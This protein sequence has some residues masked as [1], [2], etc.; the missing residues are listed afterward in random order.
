MIEINNQLKTLSYSLM[1]SWTTTSDNQVMRLYAS[2]PKVR[3]LFKF[4]N[5]N[6]FAIKNEMDNGEKELFWYFK[7]SQETFM[8]ELNY[9][10]DFT[11]TIR[12]LVK[13]K[14]RNLYTKRQLNSW[15]K[16]RRQVLDF[17]EKYKKYVIGLLTQIPCDLTE[18]IAS[19]L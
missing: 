18:N 11:S 10:I 7:L 9:L 15:I 14:E 16:T 1:V 13:G 6:F 8:D 12:I 17:E 4:L 19:Y 3:K 5:D 2:V